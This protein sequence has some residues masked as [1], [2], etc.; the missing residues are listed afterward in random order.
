MHLVASVYLSVCL[1]LCALMT[2][3]LRQ[4]KITVLDYNYRAL[5]NDFV[6][7]VEQLLITCSADLS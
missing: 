1:S 4:S 5:A 2:E 6:D 7:T 3:L